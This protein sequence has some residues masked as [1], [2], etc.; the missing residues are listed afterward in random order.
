MEKYNIGDKFEY[1]TEV[2]QVT[3]N[4]T[5]ENFTVVSKSEHGQRTKVFDYVVVATGHFSWPHNPSF[6]GEETFP[7]KVVHSHE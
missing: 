3:F 2:E 1:S 4:E 5:E 7:G 6:E